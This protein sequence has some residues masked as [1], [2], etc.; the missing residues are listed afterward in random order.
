RLGLSFLFRFSRQNAR[1]VPPGNIPGAVVG[2]VPRLFLDRWQQPG[3]VTD[4]QRFTTTAEGRTAQGNFIISDANI[5]DASFIRLQSVNLSYD[6]PQ[7]VAGRIGATS[8]RLF[9]Q[10]QNL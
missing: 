5:V 6:F 3:D 8:L 7:S 1:F 2:N 10:G 4:I 9:I